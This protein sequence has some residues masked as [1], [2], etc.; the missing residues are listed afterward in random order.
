[1]YGLIISGQSIPKPKGRYQPDNS[2]DRTRTIIVWL[3]KIEKSELSLTKFFAKYP[4]PFSRSQYY[5]YSQKLRR[6][7]ESGLQDKRSEGGN[8]KVTAETE[9]FI[10]GCVESNPEISPKWLQEAVNK[11]FEPPGEASKRITVVIGLPLVQISNNC[12]CCD[13]SALL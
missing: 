12:N 3:N 6:F 9:A 7:G 2:D 4:V 10:V 13:L 11:R 8:R 5:L 1:M